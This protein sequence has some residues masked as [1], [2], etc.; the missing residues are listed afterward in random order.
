MR[1]GYLLLDPGIGVFGSKGASV[2]VQEVIRAL[3]VAGHEVIVFCVR[4]DS[5]VPADLQ[6]VEVRRFALPKCSST[7]AREEAA[8]SVSRHIVEEAA[9]AGLDCV[10][11]RYA[12]FSTAGAQLAEEW[13]LPF[14]LEVNAP[15]IA[16]QS[17]HRELANAQMAELATQWQF[18]SASLISCVSAPVAAWVTE[19][20]AGVGNTATGRVVVVPNGVNTVR[21][22]AA[23]RPP[24]TPLGLLTVG[25]VGTLKPWHGTENLVR[26]M[27]RT[28]AHMNLVLCGDGPERPGLEELAKTLGM[29]ERV[30]FLGAVAPERIPGILHGFDIAVAPYPRGEH[31]FSPLKVYEYM[32]AG[33]PILA[34]TIGEIPELLD[35]GGC[36]VLVPPGDVDALAAGLDLLA[37]SPDLRIELGRRARKAAT[38]RHDW[39]VRV[40]R[41]LDGVGIEA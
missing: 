35:N 20:L 34:S 18:S 10:Y 30:S 25:F 5:S 8:A 17:R 24:R 39:R 29:S 14:I 27:A 37:L 13:S 28:Q 26:A 41:V 9:R 15:L 3:R 7:A 4:T 32:A 19:T 6:D 36:G 21:I 23:N 38:E 12:L 33:L 1:I 22:T 16:E 11:E 2:H 40:A 31:Y